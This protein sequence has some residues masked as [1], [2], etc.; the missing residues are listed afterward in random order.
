MSSTN[1][2]ANAVACKL[3]GLVGS[4]TEFIL[5]AICFGMSKPVQSAKPT[6]RAERSGRGGLPQP[7]FLPRGASA[8]PALRSPAH[9]AKPPVIRGTSGF[10]FRRVGALCRHGLST[11]TESVIELNDGKVLNDEIPDAAIEI[12]RGSSSSN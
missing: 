5:C 2:S 4:P 3:R 1:Y 6:R 7:A 9:T 11:M 12:A 10:V 8:Q